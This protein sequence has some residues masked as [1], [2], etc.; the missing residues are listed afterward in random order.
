MKSSRAA[1]CKKAYKFSKIQSEKGFSLIEVVI[2][3][4]IL[5]VGLLA[6]ASMQISAIKVNSTARDMTERSTVAQDK[7]EKLVAMPYN[8][9]NLDLASSPFPP[10]TTATG[11]TITWTVTDGPV[12][13]K[14]KLI[15]VTVVEGSKRTQLLYVRPAL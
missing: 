3:M 9:P 13:G 10:E 12:A 14:T 4:A 1:K 5:S 6:I 7:L 11:Y 2:A 15:N 8:D